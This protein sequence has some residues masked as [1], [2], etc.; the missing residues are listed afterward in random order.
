MIND[1]LVKS[2]IPYV[3]HA[4]AKP[5][6]SEPF[7]LSREPVLRLRS[8]HSE[9]TVHPEPVE[10]SKGDADFLRDHHHLNSNINQFPLLIARNIFNR[11]PDLGNVSFSQLPSPCRRVYRIGTEGRGKNLSHPHLYPV[12]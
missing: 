6:L 12:E 1:E 10:R 4:S 2:H 5:V 11:N 7:T 3:V 8:G 9:T